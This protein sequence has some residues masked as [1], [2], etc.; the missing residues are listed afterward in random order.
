MP[1]Y[2]YE[3]RILYLRKEEEEFENKDGKQRLFHDLVSSYCVPRLFWVLRRSQ[4]NVEV[5]SR[6]GS[7]ATNGHSRW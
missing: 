4:P 1:V 6:K 5:C 3:S 2:E 7:L